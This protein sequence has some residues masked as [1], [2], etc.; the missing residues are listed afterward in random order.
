MPGIRPY[1]PS[2]RARLSEICVRTAAH[3]GDARGILPDDGLWGEVFALPYVDHDPA[4]GFVVVSADDTAIGY[5]LGTADSTTFDRWFGHTWWPGVRPEPSTPAQASIVQYAD[6]RGA[7]AAP[8]WASAY[9]AE[10]HIDLLPEAQGTGF[11][12]TLIT[13]F[14]GALRA[15]GVPGV[16]LGV[17]RANTGA[18]GFYRKLGFIE[19]ERSDDTVVFG[20]DLRA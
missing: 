6:A 13:T 11:G 8:S 5:V 4:L 2:D 15:R 18:I 9:P 14:V 3:G 20:M 19:L 16:H 7:S 10:L 17:A 12:R 1:R